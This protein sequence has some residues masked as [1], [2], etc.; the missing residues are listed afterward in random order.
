MKKSQGRRKP[1]RWVVEQT[2]AWHN[3]FCQLRAR[4]EVKKIN[5]K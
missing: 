4:Y 5:H 3:K 1:R 2:G